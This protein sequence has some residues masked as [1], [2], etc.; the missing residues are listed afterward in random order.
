LVRSQ[1]LLVAIVV[2]VHLGFAAGAFDFLVSLA[3]VWWLERKADAYVRRRDR[4]R[5]A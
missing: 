5:E 2:V 4:E 3:A 1:L